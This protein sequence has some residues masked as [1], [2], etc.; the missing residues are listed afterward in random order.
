MTGSNAGLPPL[1]ADDVFIRNCTATGPR[2]MF[3]SGDQTYAEWVAYNNGPGRLQ[4][5]QMTLEQF[6]VR[7]RALDKQPDTGVNLT[8]GQARLSWDDYFFEVARMVSTRATCLRAQIGCVL[9]DSGRRIISTGYN[10]SPRGEVHC[11]DPGIGCAIFA[12]HCVRTIHAEQNAVDNAWELLESWITPPFDG[13]HRTY[14]LSPLKVTAYIYGPREICSH[15]ARVLWEA[16]VKET[17]CRT[18]EQTN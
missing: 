6:V 18:T 1:I 7:K 12:G 15:C 13:R 16:G 9:V 2:L 17:K 3:P 10:G 14:F 5:P 8:E 11:S 4:Y